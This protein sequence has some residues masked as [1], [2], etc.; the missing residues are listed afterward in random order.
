MTASPRTTV[1]RVGALTLVVALATSSC[2]FQGDDDPAETVQSAALGPTPVESGMPADAKPA[3][4]GQ[5]VY[6]LEAETSS[7]W[8][9]PE[10]QLAISGMQVAKS[11]YDTL[12][13][14][15]ASGEYVPYLAKTI[16]HDDS[17]RSWTITLRGGVTFH[18]GTKLDAEVVKNNLDAYRGTYAERAPLLFTF[19]FKN[20]ESVEVVNELSLTVKT[21]VPW[22]AFPAAL[23]NSGRIGIAAQAQLDA[24]KAE[25][26]NRPIGTG[27][28]SFVSWQPEVSLRVK[29]NPDYWQQAPDGKPY[30]YLDAVDFRP[31]ANSDERIA[32]LEQGELNMLHTSTAADM[33]QNLATLRDDGAI[34]L[35][36]SEDRTETSYLMLN[37]ADERLATRDVRLAIAH[38]IDPATLNELSNKGFATLAK[39]PFAPEVLGY[40]ED[41]G[42]PA[43]D[44]EAA[45]K[46]VAAME[47]AD[48]STRFSLLTSSGPAAIRTAGIQK[49][50]LEKAGFTIDLEVES[51]AGLIERVIA[52]TYEL[53]AF[54]NQPGEDPDANYNWWY[55]KGNPVNFGRFDDPVINAAL[56]KGRT[57]SDPDT[58]RTAYETVNKQFA[59]QAYNIYL[60][61]A[62]WAVA[63]SRDVH[64]ILG[65]PLPDRPDAAIST[66]LVTGHP[67]HGIWIEKD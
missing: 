12:T 29:R 56:D 3:R 53:A 46:G 20:I 34:N 60:W 39:G 31:M 51:E 38:A 65:P 30:P 63:E 19:V 41:P 9:L 55:G 43:F 66:R 59:K 17:Y 4:G 27:P 44:L 36:V 64:G 10:A 13:V 40:L 18:D 23:Y 28:F 2:M 16:T 25:C 42:A 8:C 45:K 24:P 61:Y 49:D 37:T 48:L 35:L 67:L 14:P 5:L 7:G 47:A 57:S 26:S 21:K 62:P 33:G 22:V 32:L 11:L 54:R 15:D 6:G 52:G 58:R 50:M 1:R